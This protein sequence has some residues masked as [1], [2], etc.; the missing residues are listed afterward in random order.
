[1]SAAILARAADECALPHRTLSV[2]IASTPSEAA[3]SRWG[4]FSHLAFNTKDHAHVPDGIASHQL[5]R[6]RPGR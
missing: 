3:P 2:T 1:M 6:R 4:P 5:T